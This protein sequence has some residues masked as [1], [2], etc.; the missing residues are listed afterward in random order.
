MGNDLGSD[1]EGGLDL[2]GRLSAETKDK[3]IRLAF[4]MAIFSP[5]VRGGVT[6]ALKLGSSAL[7]HLVDA[8]PWAG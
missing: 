7:A 6:A 1:G 8:K 2:R 3:G 5:R 4:R